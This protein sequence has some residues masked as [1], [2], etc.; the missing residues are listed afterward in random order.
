MEY[1]QIT[2]DDLAGQQ[3]KVAHRD[4]DE[5]IIITTEKQYI[6][7]VSDYEDSSYFAEVLT[8]ED[9]WT[10]KLLDAKTYDRYMSECG[11]RHKAEREATAIA[12]FKEAAAKVGV[13]METVKKLLDKPE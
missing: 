6:K 9:L 1:E 10:M 3:I 7:L 11:A 13:G 5:I 12:R 2:L 8:M 4:C